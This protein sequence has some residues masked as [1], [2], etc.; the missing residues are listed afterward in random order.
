M[1]I[2]N[3]TYINALLANA[4]Y[5]RLQTR[6]LGFSND[7]APPTG[8][9][10]ST[11]EQLEAL[12]ESLTAPQAKYLLDNFEVLNQE[13]SPTGGFDAVVW[14]GKAGSIYTGK[15]YISMRGTQGLTDIADD[16][17][18]SSQGVP[19]DQIVSMVN[20]WLRETA[21]KGT[22]VKQ[23]KTI[24]IIQGIINTESFALSEKN[25]IGTGILTGINSIESVNGHSLGGYLSTAFTRLFGNSADVKSIHTFNSAG[26]SSVAQ[27]SINQDF[28]II[29]GL[30]NNQG[31]S[32]NNIENIQKNYFAENGINITTNESAPTWGVGFNQYG[33][34]LSI[35]QEEGIGLSNHSMY[36]ITDVLALGTAI[37]RL[38][39]SFKLSDLNQMVMG[40]SNNPE[41]DYERLLDSLRILF[42]GESISKTIVGDNDGKNPSHVSLHTH[43]EQLIN[44]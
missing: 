32:F 24:S 10:R 7:D 31:K 40:S 34:R 35:N 42:L 38:D 26:F 2:I 4:S 1:K 20:W 21:V 8:I 6:P 44:R 5:I 28:N 11:S 37:E 16:I 33:E 36:K 18:L 27:F 17:E 39:S 29:D 14:K 22:I 9:L 19:S 41:A 25:A 43:L 13:L 15:V 3:D 12:T 30:L 23:I